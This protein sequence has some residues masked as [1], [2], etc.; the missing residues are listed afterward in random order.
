MANDDKPMDLNKIPLGKLNKLGFEPDDLTLSDNYNSQTLYKMAINKAFSRTSVFNR[1][2]HRAIV[3]YSS[4][5]D[6]SAPG[7]GSWP[8]IGSFFGGDDPGQRRY[9]CIC[10]V[11]EIDASIPAPNLNVINAALKDLPPDASAAA[12]AAALGQMLSD[13]DKL[14]LSMHRRYYTGM[15]GI[16]DKPNVGD[17]VIV[18]NEGMVLSIESKGRI[19]PVPSGTGEVSSVDAFYG[20]EAE[21]QSLESIVGIPDDVQIDADL[22]D[23]NAAIY[24]PNIDGLISHGAAMNQSSPIWAVFTKAFCYRLYQRNGIQVG[25]TSVFRSP[26]KQQQLMDSWRAKCRERGYNSDAECNKNVPGRPAEA[27]LHQTGWAFDCNLYQNGER[28]AWMSG[29]PNRT[30]GWKNT[31]AVEIA[32]AMDFRWGGDFTNPD[33]VHFSGKF[34]LQ[35]SARSILDNARA[36]NVSPNRYTPRPFNLT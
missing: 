1:K 35:E 9:S 6:V 16:A 4:S 2:Q 29:M 28:V 8:I 26:A 34:I 24:D 14:I 32:K 5:D 17:I 31:G 10:R 36:Q 23:A 20:S 30:Q 33:H 21:G 7:P 3:L 27:S 11:P 22:Y 13:N 19:G 25:F 15:V 12:T 18:D